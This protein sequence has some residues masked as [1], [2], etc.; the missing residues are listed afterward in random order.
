MGKKEVIY[1]K[2]LELGGFFAAVFTA[3]YF[4]RTEGAV[5]VNLLL[6]RISFRMKGCTRSTATLGRQSMEWCRAPTPSQT[7]Q[8]YSH[9]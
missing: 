7:T 1:L 3:S 9:P 4:C 5:D 2:I 6:V 8:L